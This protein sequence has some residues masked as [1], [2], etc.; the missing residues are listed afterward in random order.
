[1]GQALRVP[2]FISVLGQGAGA[3]QSGVQTQTPVCCTTKA[4]L[5]FQLPYLIDGGHK[6]TQSNAILRYIARKH[7]MCKWGWGTHAYSPG[8]GWSGTLRVSLCC[9]ATGGETEEE[10]IRVDILEN[11]TMDVRL[12]MARICY[13]PDFVSSLPL[14]WVA[15]SLNVGQGPSALVLL[16]FEPFGATD[17]PSLSLQSPQSDSQNPQN[18]KCKL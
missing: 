12:H 11:Q 18:I 5:F 3:G 8:L 16:P 4:M 1:M 9:V 6:L 13:S 15:Q 7:N 2:G 10:K 17:P 14:G